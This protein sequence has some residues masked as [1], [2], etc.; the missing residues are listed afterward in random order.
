MASYLR[1]WILPGLAIALCG[2]LGWILVHDA[3]RSSREPDKQAG[4]RPLPK[5]TFDRPNPGSKFGRQPQPTRTDEDDHSIPGERLVMFDSDEAYRNF[6]AGL[7]GSDL[8]LLG[9]IDRLRVL[10]LGYDDLNSLRDQLDDQEPYGNYSVYVPDPPEESRGGGPGAGFGNSLYEWLGI[11]Q[12]N[13]SYGEGV[14]IAMIDTGISPDSPLQ[15]IRRID[16]LAESGLDAPVFHPHGEQMASISRGNDPQ[17]QGISPSSPIISIRIGDESGAANSFL[18]AE[19]IVRAVDEGGDIINISMGSDYKSTIVNAAVDYAAENGVLIVASA[20]NNGSPDLSH[21]AANDYVISVGAL[22]ANSQHAP[23]SNRGEDLNVAAP[24]VG[25]PALSDGD[26][27][28]SSGTSPG[29]MVVTSLLAATA[30]EMNLRINDAYEVFANNLTEVGPPGND[31]FYGGG[32]PDFG[33]ILDSN[34]TGL[35]DVAMVEP[36]LLPASLDNPNDVL[37]F[38]VENRGTETVS[39]VTLNVESELGLRPYPLG[40][41]GPDEIQTVALNIPPSMESLTLEAEASITTNLT[42]D[43]PTN[44]T[45]SGTLTLPSSEAGENGGSADP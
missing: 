40:S 29:T 4:P 18:L 35:Y 8:T 25:I 33:R 42:D 11:P 21:P 13:A 12:D 22:D 44:N 14:T 7:E 19:A 32:Y 26:L 34:T 10:R 15:N 17:M 45:V 6:L 24:G 38:T 28:W 1:K 16:L 31:P 30:S 36:F 5:P 2:A 37:L 43:R 39:R 27:V 41:L 3:S 9:R 23:F 20:G